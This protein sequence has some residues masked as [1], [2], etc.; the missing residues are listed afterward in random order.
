MLFRSG[1]DGYDGKVLFK[2]S[3][4]GATW[5]KISSA[6]A[7]QIIRADSNGKVFFTEGN[8]K[9]LYVSNNQGGSFSLINSLSLPN[10]GV[11]YPED[12]AFTKN[13]MFITKGQV[14]YSK[15]NGT[16]FSQLDKLTFP[17]AGGFNYGPGGA[18]YGN[19]GDSSNRMEIIGN[20]LF[21]ASLDGI[22]FIDIDNLNTTVTWSTGEV[23]NKITVTP[24]AT[25][26]G[27][28]STYS[29]TVSYGSLSG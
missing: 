21:V 2:S 28:T 25:S 6:Y 12:I 27:Y 15:D 1:G 29:A 23:G 18:P 9:P 22:K 7:V 14:Y 4:A 20:R 3:D 19:Y 17:T 5:S 24:V 8:T 11:S 10:S 13:I 16:N 26:P